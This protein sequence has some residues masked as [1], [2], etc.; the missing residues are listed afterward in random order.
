MKKIILVFCAVL[1]QQLAFSQSQNL[2]SLAKGDYLGFNAVFDV[3]ENL[4]G[5]VALYGYGKSGEKTKKFEYVILDKNLNPVANKE[6]QGDITAGNYVAYMDFKGQIVLRPSESDDTQIKKKLFF[7]PSS[8]VIDLKTN[9]IQKK[10]EYEYDGEK[11]DVKKDSTQTLRNSYKEKLSEY[12]Q[13]GF[14]K[15]SSVYEIKEGGFLVLECDYSGYSSKNEK[16]IRFDD[17]KKELWRFEYNPSESKIE[18]KLKIVDK[19]ENYIYALFGKFQKKTQEISFLVIDIK[20]GKQIYNKPIP[21]SDSDSAK[22]IMDY[23]E[24]KTFDDK[25]VLFGYSTRKDRVNGYTR[26]IINKKD[27]SSS[28]D[29]LP[30]KDGIDAQLPRLD[31]YGAVEGGYYLALKDLFILKDGTIGILTEK[32]KTVGNYNLPKTSDLVYIYT[33]KNFKLSGVTV[34][35]KKKTYGYDNSDYLFSQYLNQGKDVVF[36]FRDYQKN[37]DTKKKAW[38]LF[39]NTLIDGKF[40][41]EQIPI[42]SKENFISPYVAKEGY[43]LLQ[44]YNNK[45]KYNQIRLE[46]LNY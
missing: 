18:E 33:D 44:E 28:F 21:A 9:T 16:L 41:Q 22:K 15:K 34:F 35:D 36:F 12:R 29:V 37:E 1:C 8:M 3:N 4:Y 25:F 32:Y 38:A 39:I 13:N 14:Y 7:E 11:I 40:N 31:A 30:F 27:Y 24:S 23:L 46:K 5:Y 42:S 43:I 20:T 19:D 10:V 26:L 17:N 45:D 2:Y 6:F